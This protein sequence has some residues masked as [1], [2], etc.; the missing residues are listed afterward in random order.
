MGKKKKGESVSNA[1]STAKRSPLSST[2]IRLAGFIVAFVGILLI[3]EK[4]SITNT[5]LEIIAILMMLSGLFMVSGNF[6]RMLNKDNSSEVI[7]YF[8]FG[9]LL[10]V[11]GVLFIIYSVTIST[12]ALVIIGCA[13]AGYGLLMLIKTLVSKQGK[14]RK[15]LNAVIACFMVIVGILI[16]LLKVSAIGDASSHVCYIIFGSFATALGVTEILVY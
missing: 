2:A 11:A 12:W 15:T 9:I 16:A 10:I 6:K 3:I 5:A 14:T 13:I 4:Q 8:F 1:T 7:L